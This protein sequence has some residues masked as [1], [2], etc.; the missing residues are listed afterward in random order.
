MEDI[1]N[2]MTEVAKLPWYVLLMGFGFA[3]WVYYYNVYVK[4]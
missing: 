1:L 2:L 3:V 4:K